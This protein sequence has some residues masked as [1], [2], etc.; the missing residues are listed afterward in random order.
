MRCFA[1]C[2][3]GAFL[4]LTVLTGCGAT[5]LPPL[6]AERSGS[7][8]V[9]RWPSAS[10]NV[11]VEAA[12]RLEV[13]NTWTVLTNRPALR[14]PDLAVTNAIEP[15]SKFYRLAQQFDF[16]GKPIRFL[17]LFGQT[18]WG[19]TSPG[20]VTGARIFH[21][22]GV[23]V[24]R[25]SS[26]DHIYVADTGNNRIL[27]FRSYSSTNAD[28][29]FGQPDEFSG[30]ANGDGN[31]GFHGPTTRTNLCLLN[32]PE[33]PNVAEQ[34]MRLNFDVDTSGNLYVADF[35][36]NRV[37]IYNAPFSD[38]KSEGKG[39]NIPDRL[40]GQDNWTSNAVNR[41]LG[42]NARDARSLFISWGNPAGFDHVSAR[43]VSV[44]T[45]GNVWVADTF[46]S[47]VLRFPPGAT[48]ANLVL[49][50]AD[51]TSRVGA[52]QFSSNPTNAPLNRMC[53]PVL[54]RVN[55]D[56]DEL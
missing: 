23:I 33:N 3:W 42:P 4:G 17:K 45:N 11:V 19:D 29:V 54:A 28:L 44:D 9:L 15:G 35:Y 14:G 1:F 50:Q 25:G 13:S 8:V 2:L 49:G 31:L 26:G 46:N 18:H 7:N 43:G 20:R 22:A 52:C 51:F 34:W 16:Y 30:A 27:G 38:D 39:D 6:A 5:G 56:T 41:G 21:S 47:R 48:N 37:V 36:N 53:T 55:P 40:I 24:D 32:Y 10:S 12:N